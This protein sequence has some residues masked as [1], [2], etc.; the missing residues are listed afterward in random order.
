MGMEGR[1]DEAEN[2]R[3]DRRRAEEEEEAECP[4]A[5]FSLSSDSTEKAAV[6]GSA[7]FML[8]AGR[9]DGE[10]RLLCPQDREADSERLRELERGRLG[11]G[12]GVRDGVVEESRSDALGSVVVIFTCRLPLWIGESEVQGLQ[13]FR[14]RQLTV[15]SSSPDSTMPLNTPSVA[16]SFSR[17]LGGDAQ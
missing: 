4:F 15:A 2:E 6:L 12:M 5:P 1:E 14:P 9:E 10:A 17:S 16:E 3:G 13:A 7:P 8:A 11:N